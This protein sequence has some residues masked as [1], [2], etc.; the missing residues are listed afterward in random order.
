MSTDIFAAQ[1]DRTVQGTLGHISNADELIYEKPY[2]IL[3]HPEPGFEFVALEPKDSLT[4]DVIQQPGGEET[5]KSYLTVLGDL[6]KDHLEAEQV[7]LYDWRI[8]STRAEVTWPRPPDRFVQLPPAACVHADESG[9][10]GR[11]IVTEHLTDEE[12]ERLNKGEGRFRIINIWRPLVPMV[13]VK[14]LALC[15]WRSV[16]SSDWELCDQVLK[17]HIDEAMYLKHK[18]THQWW[19]LPDQ[20]SNEII[21]FVVWDSQKFRQG[22]QETN[23][24][25]TASTPHAAFDLPGSGSGQIRESIEVRSIIWTKH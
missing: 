1:Q 5:V 4:L 21:L 10:C 8:R 11:K 24:C 7:I 17:D 14:P 22:K 3:Y 13:T 12:R 6:L 23:R 9:L 15:D 16:H 18:P 25:G 20:K 19:W 2:E